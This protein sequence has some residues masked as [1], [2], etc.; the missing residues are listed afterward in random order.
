MNVIGIIGSP[1]QN[2]NVSTLVDEVLKG[3][4]EAG[5]STKAYRLGEMKYA[6]CQA[7]MYCKSHDKCRQDDDMSKLMEEMKTADA[8]V[9]G[10]PIYYWQFSS[11]FRTFIDRLYMFLGQDFS[12]TLPAGKKAVVVTSQGNPDV[13]S[14]RN[15]FT[16]FNKLLEM[17]GFEKVDEL[18]LTAGNSPS[19]AKENKELM[20]QA[21]S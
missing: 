15:V 4:A 16:D 20:E 14:F 6:G 7:C 10:S 13:D 12:V 18:H 5:H 9:F 19:T 2:G 1:R 3:A 11:Q 21:R 17:Y 8:V